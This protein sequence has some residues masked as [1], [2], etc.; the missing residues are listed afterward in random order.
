MRFSKPIIYILNWDSYAKRIALLFLII[1]LSIQNSFLFLSE[2][3]SLEG[4]L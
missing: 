4:Q 3:G 1:E 2:E